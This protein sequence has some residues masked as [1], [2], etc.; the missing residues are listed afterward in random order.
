MK[1]GLPLLAPA[2]INKPAT[3]YHNMSLHVVF[4]LTI[5]TLGILYAFRSVDPETLPVR[6]LIAFFPICYGVVFTTFVFTRNRAEIV[7]TIGFRALLWPI[8]YSGMSILVLLNFFF[9]FD[10]ST[11]LQGAF[12]KYLLAPILIPYSLCSF[13]FF[14]LCAVTKLINNKPK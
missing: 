5:I 7:K 9:G 14:S 4:F 10:P 1:F 8:V 11:E 12:Y 3:L 6:I 13:V 2:D